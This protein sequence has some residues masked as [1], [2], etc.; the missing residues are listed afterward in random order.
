MSHNKAIVYNKT[1]FQKSFYFVKY[2]LHFMRIKN[3]A[4]TSD[5]DYLLWKNIRKGLLYSFPLIQGL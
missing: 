5:L 4:P 1:I 2:L 3:F